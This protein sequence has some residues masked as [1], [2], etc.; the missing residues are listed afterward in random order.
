M[1][2]QALITTIAGA[3]YGTCAYSGDNGPAA[4]A[5]L[6]NPQMAITDNAGNIYFSDAANWVIRMI[7][8]AGIISTIAGNGTRGT[9]GD[10]GPATSANLGAVYQLAYDGVNNICFGDFLAYKIRCVSLSTGIIQGYGTGNPVSAGD[11]G[12]FASASFYMPTGVVFVQ[13]AVPP[14]IYN[15]LYICDMAASVVRKVAGDTGIITTVVGTGLSGP[16]GD[17]G[18]ATSATLQE[19]YSLAYFNGSLYIADSGNDR[20]R[21]V[22]LSTG[23][24]TTV[25]GNGVPYFAGDG[26]PATSAQLSPRELTFDNVG[27]MYIGDAGRIRKVDLSGIITTY[28]GNGNSGIGPDN[29]PPSQ[30]YFSG[31]D[32][33]YW[34]APANQLLISDGVNKI[35]QVSYQGTTTTVAAT[36]TSVPPG[37]QVTI[38]ATV[39]ASAATGNVDFIINGVLA[40]TA[41]VSAGQ[42]VFSWTATGTTNTVGAIYVGDATYAPSSSGIV[43]V[44]VQKN[45]TTTTIAATPNPSNQNQT[46]TLTSTVSPETATGTIQF[47]GAGA[48]LG[49]ATLSN[50]TASFS[51]SFANA[52]PVVLY[53][54]YSGDAN[55][56]NSTST[57]LTQTVL[58]N[59]AVSLSSGQNPSAVNTAVYFTAGVTPST[60]TGTIQFFDGGSSLGSATISGGSV[61]FSATFTTQGTHSITAVYSG[62]ANDAGST[63]ATLSQSVK[64]ITGLSLVSSLNPAVVGQ[65]VTFTVTINSAAT[66]T[67]QFS[68]GATALGTITVSAGVAAYSTSSLV[69]GAHAISV[70][71]SGDANY[72]SSSSA[73]L[74]E[75][76]NPKA[77][78]T[79]TV[80]SSPNPSNSGS[81]VLIT[82]TV[83]PSTA[84]GTIQFLDGTTVLG[85]GAIASGAAS[86]S[87]SAL[88]TGKHSIT[89]AYSGDSLNLASTS[90]AITQTVLT[91]T[92]VSLSSTQNPSPVGGAFSFLVTVSPSSASGTVQFLD[93]TTAI[94]SG[95]LSGGATSLNIS[96]LTQGT[97]IITAVYSGDANDAGSTSAPLS[98]AVKL[99]TGLGY[100]SS[101]NPSIVGQSVTLTVT[102]ASA[103]TGTVQ[104]IDSGTLLA[105]V[106]VASGVAQYSTANL[107]QG[108]HAITVIYSGDANYLGFQSAPLSQV[109]NAKA[110]SSTGVSSSVNPS[111]VG[112]SVKFTASVTPTSATG[113]VQF[114]D[115]AT[116]IG[117]A[118]LSSGSASITT[119]SLAQGAHSITAAYGGDAADTA[120][121]S[122]VLTQTVN[123]VAPSAPSNL[124]ATSAGTSQINLAW[125]AS[126]TSGVT[127]DVYES[128]TSGFTPSAANRIA[129]GI[130]TTSY[131]AT[132]LTASTTY[133]YR[134]SAVNSG[135][136]SADTNQASAATSGA[137]ACSVSYSVSSQWPGGFG[138]TYSIKNTGSTPITDWVLTWTW[139]GTQAVTQAWNANYTQTGANVKFTYE[140]YNATISAGSTLSG[141]GFNGTWSGS[142]IAP[143]AF[144]VNGTLCH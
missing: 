80:A 100:T 41:P 77:T 93:G 120:S 33:V 95:T 28:A 82:A 1:P 85:S 49:S 46:V 103:A 87:T 107:A 50:G 22:N 89:A 142:N 31:V 79:T 128:T 52:G 132:G 56:A 90:A 118:T 101:L 66:G 141:M 104:F 55:N 69:Q 106:T 139:P 92:T 68:D 65:S 70:I 16:L 143:T 144:Y 81:N 96:T 29:V 19:P 51:Y 91:T 71:Y 34:N 53:A 7:N 99:N 8:P 2:G 36:P 25:A 14:A 126:T 114:L 134:V 4:A 94:G 133:Y 63:S 62:D 76:I 75:T 5:V 113:T 43:G 86:F 116:V 11:G 74:S 61:L 88:A 136:E 130:T 58:A 3:K 73:P 78:T 47:Y 59:T 124:T 135:G 131:T 83:S 48:L 20:I 17:G 123:A 26:G 111:T 67:I 138:G 54:T 9:A 24:I 122:S 37:G 119:T 109:V 23:I 38:T 102:I 125:T 137:M 10:G 110:T 140:S 30:T 84:T 27:Q 57:N 97:H 117:T 121:S 44:T 21:A 108:T 64:A 39:S 98:Q 18:P 35:R 112:Q 127:Y 32:G 13:R 6:C 115:G 60:A 42:A 129:S 45:T 72:L 15:D 12:P 105:T 40:G